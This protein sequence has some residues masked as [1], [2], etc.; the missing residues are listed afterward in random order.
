MKK[1]MIVDDDEIVCRIAERILNKNYETVSVC[2]GIAALEQATA[3]KPDLI[4]MDL[5]MPGMDG[6]EVMEQLKQCSGFDIPVVFMTSEDDIESEVKGLE[7]GARDYIRKP[8]KADIL[9]KRIEMVIQNEDNRKVLERNADADPLTGLLNR[10]AAA[11][12]VDNYL[13][14]SK[15]HGVLLMMDIDHFKQVNDTY[16]HKM[17]DRVI[18]R[19][20]EVLKSFTRAYDILGRLGGDEF[21]I[22]YK[23][24]DNAEHLSER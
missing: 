3:E 20:A 21:V 23:D 14:G 6:Y 4:L 18:M 7:M 16:G 2:S 11:R 13:Q 24:Y 12:E 22:F 8:F 17:G 15:A 19:V 10:R 1:I 9:L 5:N